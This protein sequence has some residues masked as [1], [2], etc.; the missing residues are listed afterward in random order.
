MTPQDLPDT[1]LSAGPRGMKVFRTIM[2][3]LAT[4]QAAFAGLT[5]MVGAFADGGDVWS[6]LLIVLLHPLSAAALLVLVVSPRPAA[7]RAFG[8]AALLTATVTADVTFALLIAQGAVKGDWGLPL[9][10]AAIPAVGIAYALTL[11]LLRP[12]SSPR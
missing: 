11:T 8:V 4:V 9:A 1:E 12:R 10:F 5:A 6:R 7:A 2:L 3:V